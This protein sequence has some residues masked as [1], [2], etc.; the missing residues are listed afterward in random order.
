MPKDDPPAGVPE[1]VL[2]YG[3]MMSLLLCFFVLLAAMSELKTEEKTVII[4]SLLKQFGDPQTVALFIAANAYNQEVREM[5][6][7][8]QEKAEEINAHNKKVKSGGKGPPGNKKRVR[9]IREGSRRTVGGPVLFREGQAQLTADGTEDIRQIAQSLRGKPQVV[10]VRAYMPPGGVPEGSTFK[11]PAALAYARMKE[12]AGILEKDGTLPREI[13]RL[14]IAA[15]VEAI[16]MPSANS[17]EPMRERVDIFA[18]EDTPGASGPA[19]R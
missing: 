7:I 14:T 12:V 19:A 15:P 3:D 11:T 13:I 8:L 2:T 17:G 1:W 5:G 16:T 4:E 9:T 10:E 6:Q 18:L